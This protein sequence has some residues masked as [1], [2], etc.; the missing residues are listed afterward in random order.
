MDPIMAWKPAPAPTVVLAPALDPPPHL[1]EAGAALW[2]SLTDHWDFNDPAA[3]A[4]LSDACVARDT[5]VRLHG[6]VEVEGDVIRATNGMKANPLI[7]VE[8]QARNLTARLLAQLG[9]FNDET[10]RGPGRPPK[11]GSW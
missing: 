8:L 7:M 3:P 9:L 11:V 6:R 2:R 10:K 4:L 1:E 5:A